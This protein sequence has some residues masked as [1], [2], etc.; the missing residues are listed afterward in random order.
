M[1]NDEHILQVN[2]VRWFRL[3]YPKRI[4]F[5]IANGGARNAVTGAMLKAEGVTRGV[6]DLLIPEPHNNYAGL[7]AEMKTKKGVVSPYQR[8]MMREL[9]KRGYK[10]EVC[11]TFDDFQRVIRDY[12]V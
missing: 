1:R 10:C 3:Q 2:C 12:F 5:A 4:I 7:W 11:R 8:D 9:E 6:P